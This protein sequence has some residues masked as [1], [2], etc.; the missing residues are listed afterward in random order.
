MP[1]PRNGFRNLIDT[2]LLTPNA[3]FNAYINYDYGQNRDST[4]TTA[5]VTTGDN[6]LN[7]WQGVAVAAREQVTGKSALAGRFEYFTDPTRSLETGT[8]QNLTGIHRRPYEYKWVEGCW[9]G[10]SIALDF[11][12]VDFFHKNATEM[13]DSQNTITVG[14]VAF[15]GPKR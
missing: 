14:M 9:R 6:N 13:V 7:H 5:G 10:L 1:T 15:F 8:A 12:S 3:K 4:V 11:S 2:T